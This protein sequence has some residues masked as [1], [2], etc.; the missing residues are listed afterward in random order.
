MEIFTIARRR[1]FVDV[2]RQSKT[3]YIKTPYSL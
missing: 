1:F 3:H 2:N